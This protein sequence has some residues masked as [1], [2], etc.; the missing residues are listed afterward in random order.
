VCTR[1]PFDRNIQDV[2][3]LAAFLSSSNSF[4]AGMPSD[5]LQL[6]CTLIGEHALDAMVKLS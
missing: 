5:G 2:A 1:R 4:W 6:L 3:V